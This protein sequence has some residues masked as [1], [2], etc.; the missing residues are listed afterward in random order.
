MGKAAFLL[1]QV[2]EK[3][4]RIRLR[5][6]LHPFILHRILFDPDQVFN[7]PFRSS[8]RG[9]GQPLHEKSQEGSEIHNFSDDLTVHIGLS[10]HALFPHFFPARF[11]LGFDQA[12]HLPGGL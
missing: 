11:K 6:R 5:K 12:D 4:E 8:Y 7:V 9:K 10:H 2:G 1:F 3:S